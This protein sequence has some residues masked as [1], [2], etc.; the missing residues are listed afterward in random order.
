MLFFLNS[1][2]SL[3]N[4]SPTGVNA[5]STGSTTSPSSITP[6]I[7]Y[8]PNVTSTPAMEA[9]RLRAR[10]Q[11]EDLVLMVDSDLSSERNRAQKHIRTHVNR[12]GGNDRIQAY[13]WSITGNPT[14]K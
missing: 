10:Q 13:G 12:S 14:Q 8:S 7:R 9:M 4:A 3:F 2:N 5:G 6:A 1:F 11:N